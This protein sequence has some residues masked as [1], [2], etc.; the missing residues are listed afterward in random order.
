MF[1][2]VEKSIYDGRISYFYAA[3]KSPIEMTFYVDDKGILTER[4]GERRA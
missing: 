3:K 1:G 2:R 4:Y